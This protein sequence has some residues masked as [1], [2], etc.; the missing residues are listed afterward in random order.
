MNKCAV[1]VM[2]GPAHLP[3]L[4]TSLH[5]L[6][7]H[8]NG[9]VRVYAWPESYEIASRVCEDFGSRTECVLREPTY[10]GKNAQFFDK[11]HVMLEAPGDVNLYLDADTLIEGSLDPLFEMGSKGFVATQF[12][13][14]TTAG[15]VIQKRIGRLIDREGVP[16]V[17]LRRLLEGPPQPSVNGGIWAC[18]PSSP[19]L[20]QWRAWTGTVLDIFI[21]DETVL[22]LVTE[23][24]RADRC[25]FSR[26][27]IETSGRFNYSPKMFYKQYRPGCLAEAGV[28]IWHGHGDCFTRPN[29][30]LEGTEMWMAVYRECLEENIGGMADWRTDVSHKFLDR[31][32]AWLSDKVSDT[33]KRWGSSIAGYR[34][35]LIA[36]ADEKKRLQN[37]AKRLQEATK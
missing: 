31:L 9:P 16:Q 24:F 17:A 2:S 25:G 10:R 7:D 32:E 11:L 14:W 33:A 37:E 22:H 27:Q 21:A 26:T 30:S 12:C 13:D 1:Y 19:A 20:E 3:Y 36:Q 28:T 5:T 15:G 6:R 34:C 18:V 8:Y 29:K 23:E 35:Y 4:V